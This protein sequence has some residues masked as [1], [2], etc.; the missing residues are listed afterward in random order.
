[1]SK[2]ILIN[3]ETSGGFMQ[4]QY[5]V[6]RVSNLTTSQEIF[7]SLGRDGVFELS[8]LLVQPRDY[9]NMGFDT[10]ILLVCRLEQPEESQA[11]M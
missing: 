2:S 9:C 3:R 10:F 6:G 11:L 8:H 7:F 5:P 1:M 4:S